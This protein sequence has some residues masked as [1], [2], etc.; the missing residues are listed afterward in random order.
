MDIRNNRSG[1]LF[2]VLCLF[3][4]LLPGDTMAILNG[5]LAGENVLS[6]WGSIILVIGA[7]FIGDTTGYLLGRYYGGEI[8]IAADGQRSGLGPRRD[9]FLPGPAK[10]SVS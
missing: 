6:L 9:G 10:I 2:R 5:I 1:T 8:V 3:G 7:V 4:V